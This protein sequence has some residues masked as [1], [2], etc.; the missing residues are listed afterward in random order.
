MA[1]KKQHPDK[2]SEK[3]ASPARRTPASLEKKPYPAPA[4]G[5]V[6]LEPTQ[7][8]PGQLL[9]LQRTIGNQA[10]TRRLA[11]IVQRED[12]ATPLAGDELLL[13][14][15]AKYAKANFLD[16]FKDKVKNNVEPWGLA[17]TATAVK[18]RKVKFT[19]G[20]M[21]A[22]TLKWDPAWGKQPATK[23]VPFSMAPIA[24][25]TSV[26]GVHKLKGWDSVDAGDQTKLDDLLGGEI[27]E[28]SI[29]ARKHLQ[30]QFAGLKTKSEN[31]QANALTAVVSAKDALPGVVS[32]PVT[33]ATT[34]YKL[35]GP[36]EHK[37][38]Q[39]QGTK[40]D[41]EV[42]E[43]AYS[44]GTKL[45]IAAPKGPTPGLHNHSVAKAAEAGSYLPKST[46]AVV[47]TVLLNPIKNPKD[48]EWAVK[49]NTP[50]FTSYMTAGKSGIVT[51][52]PK[53]VDKDLASDEYMR[54]TM[55]HETGHTWSYK[56]WG[57]DTSKGKWVD[58]KK[59]MNEDKTAV[60]QYA[61]NSISE[62]V[63]ETIQIY[64]STKNSPR[65]AEYRKIVP[66]RF[67]MLDKEYK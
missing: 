42:W 1:A 44:D 46:R 40:A 32:E 2:R 17:F 33:T 21:D 53:E 34:T 62:D 14:K 38:Y 45:T 22:V 51:I 12:D 61:T 28:L 54:G 23:E 55:I 59:A 64:V 67:K 43:A 36:T 6:R 65:N 31:D 39:F 13:T 19:D 4:G 52:Y 49:Y 10:V 57:T 5:P 20:E 24:A 48:P 26:T 58:W 29:A 11:T 47:N 18:L 66:N 16:W 3:P 63:A 60:S 56:T 8:S 41:A 50:G 37:E 15:E 25:K 35:T 30:G 9:Q 7:A 27:N